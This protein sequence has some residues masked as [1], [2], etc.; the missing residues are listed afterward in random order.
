LLLT[1]TQQSDTGFSIHLNV[2]DTTSGT[3]RDLT[4][5]A[6]LADKEFIYTTRIDWVKPAP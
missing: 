3:V 5:A 4:P 1:G 2:M 6:A